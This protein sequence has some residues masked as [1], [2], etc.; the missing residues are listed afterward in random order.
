MLG[1]S[2]PV[3]ADINPLMLLHNILGIVLGNSQDREAPRSRY[4][5]SPNC[6]PTYQEDSFHRKV[7]YYD[8]YDF[9]VSAPPPEAYQYV[10][11]PGPAPKYLYRDKSIRVHCRGDSHYIIYRRPGW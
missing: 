2:L 9:R 3:R 4:Y 1:V 7:I 11:Y 8:G 6:P 10:W 5:T